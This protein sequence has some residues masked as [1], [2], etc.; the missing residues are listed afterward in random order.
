M[1][2]ESTNQRAI[3]LAAAT[4]AGAVLFRVNSG[5]A[6]LGQGKAQRLTDGSVLIPGG[7]PIALGLALV[8]GEPAVGQSDLIG[9][10]TLTITPDMVG[11]RVAVITAIECKR[12][13]GGRTSADQARFID[14]VRSA[15]GIAGVAKSADEAVAIVKGYQPPLA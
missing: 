11:R 7:R 3:W 8:S 15:G 6:W 1:A 12:T 5:K 2:G 14:I 4:L 10:R 13:D 9:W